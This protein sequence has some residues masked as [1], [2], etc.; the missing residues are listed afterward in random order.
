MGT[1]S[2]KSTFAKDPTRQLSPK[3]HYW[4]TGFDIF[5]LFGVHLREILNQPRKSAEL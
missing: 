5:F 3:T 1:L 4:T 2:T